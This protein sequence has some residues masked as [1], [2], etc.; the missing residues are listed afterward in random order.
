MDIVMKHVKMIPI[1]I[2]VVVVAIYVIQ[3]IL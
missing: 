2:Q 1:E 3:I